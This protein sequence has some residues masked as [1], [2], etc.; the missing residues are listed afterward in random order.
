MIKNLSNIDMSKFNN[1]KM[2]IYIKIN[3]M[4]RNTTNKSTRTNKNGK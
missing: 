3:V 2:K 4:G 1:L